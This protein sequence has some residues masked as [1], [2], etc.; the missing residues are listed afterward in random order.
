MKPELYRQV[1]DVSVTAQQLLDGLEVCFPSELLVRDEDSTAWRQ[2]ANTIAS[3]VLMYTLDNNGYERE[4]IIES[5]DGITT[6]LLTAMYIDQKTF[7]DALVFYSKRIGRGEPPL[8]FLI[9]RIEL[10][11]RFVI[12]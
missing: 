11:E 1:V 8:Q 7:D 10:E 12:Q 5:K 9:K 3:L 6:N 2:M 4:H